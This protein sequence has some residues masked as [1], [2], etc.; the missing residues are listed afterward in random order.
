MNAVCERCMHYRRPR[1]ASQ[2]LA[3]ALDIADGPVAT[4]LG[5][6][7]EDEQK[8]LENEATFK[9]GRAN[10][11][12]DTW[13]TRPQ[14]SAFCAA[15]EAG[16]AWLIPELHNRG[17]SCPDFK[18]GTS[19]LQP[20]QTCA[21][22]R[23][24]DG[25]R[26]DHEREA[27]FGRMLEEDTVT[28]AKS[29]SSDESLLTKHREGV[30]ARKSLEL[31][32]AYA[33]KGVLIDA[34]RYLD[35]CGALSTPEREEYVVCVLRNPYASCPEYQPVPTTPAAP[36]EGTEA[37][38][39]PAVGQTGVAGETGEVG[40]AGELLAML[41]WLLQ[42]APPDD[43]QR[44]ASELVA[45]LW[46]QDQAARQFLLEVCRPAFQQC[47]AMPEEMAE[48]WREQAQPGLVA[49]LRSATSELA[50]R[51]VAEYDR[52]NAPLAVGEPPLTREIADAFVDVLAFIDGITSGSEP[53]APPA[54][55]RDLWISRMAASWPRLLPQVR[56]WLAAMP[57]E[58]AQ[59]RYQWRTLDPSQRWQFAQ[60]LQTQL[61]FTARGIAQQLAVSAAQTGSPGVLWSGG[62]GWQQGPFAAMAAS[63]AP[64]P[65]QPP[66]WIAAEMAAETGDAPEDLLAKITEKQES[67]EEKAAQE[68]PEL[69]LQMKM[70]NRMQ[71]SA[72]ISNMMNLEHETCMA[73]IKNIK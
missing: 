20:C 14:M 10:T 72:L 28:Q 21:H 27:V 5:K 11:V 70:H 2:L 44:R 35:W 24:A 53:I 6:I 19:P 26:L 32:G 18:E 55:V 73:I 39:A 67:E 12:D 9:R 43:M 22:R 57:V 66:A 16:G 61:G 45:D 3:R 4:A 36:P 65:P 69:A 46:Q 58:W 63:S 68:N 52:A 49:A 56:A 31:S 30:A 23:P 8:W 29:A 54:P 13:P 41:S 34:P 33:A 62:T 15:R 37:P 47:Q 40:A 38:A 71:R 60:Q 42:V 50:A 25:P 48:V 51:F 59:L 17:G 1:P 64:A 7:V